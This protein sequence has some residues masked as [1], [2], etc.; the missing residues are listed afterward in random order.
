MWL[1]LIV[2]FLALL[3]IIGGSLAGGI[4]TIVLIPLA[5]IAVLTAIAYSYFGGAAQ[6]RAGRDRRGR[7]PSA[8]PT[9][10]QPSSVPRPSTPEELADARRAN[11]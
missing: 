9:A 8:P 1:L 11:Q 4:F 5:A 7:R 10:Q 3:G 6:R 2:A